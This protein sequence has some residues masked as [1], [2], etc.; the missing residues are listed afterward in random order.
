MA[1]YP[2]DQFDQLP[3]DLARI[4]A[5]RAPPKGGRG[6]IGFAWAVLATGVLVF[7]GLF[8]LSRFLGVDVGLPIFAEAT[9]PT[10]TPTPTPTA[11]PLTDPR[12]LDPARALKITILNG[13]P[14]AG[15]ENTVDAALT[16][17]GWPID[18]AALASEKEDRK[19]V[20]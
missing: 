16:A 15:I 20:V 1:S 6:W 11:A 9:T 13:T 3:A 2:K 18:S 17:V 10:P 7:G 19:S 5:H 14:T 12:K 8:G 4:G